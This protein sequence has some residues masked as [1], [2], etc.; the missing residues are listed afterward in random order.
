MPRS[1][2]LDALLGFGLKLV[3]SV[4][5]LGLSIY[6]SRRMGAENFGVFSLFMSV[7]LPLSVL[8]RLGF[9]IDLLRLVSRAKMQANGSDLRGL[10]RQS[11]YVV[12]FTS[13]G[14]AFLLHLLGVWAD[15]RGL[16]FEA[17]Q[18]SG[19][20]ALALPFHA[21]LMLN[22]AFLRGNHH[23][24]WAAVHENLMVNLL[25]FGILLVSIEF[26]SLE[27]SVSALVMGIVLASLSSLVHTAV[28]MGGYSLDPAFDG[29]PTIAH[30]F[31]NALPI[32]GTS[33]ASIGFATLDVFLLSFYVDYT[34]LG[35]YTAAAKLVSFVSFPVLAVIGMVGPRMSDADARNDLASIRK[36]YAESTRLACLA[37]LPVL[38]AIAV[39]PELLL[40]IFGVGFGKAVTTVYIL[41]GGQIANLLMGP[42]GYLLWMTGHAAIL[43]KVTLFALLGF[44]FSSLILMPM[45]GMDGAA[46]ALSAAFILKGLGCAWTVRNR[47]GIKPIFWS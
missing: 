14:F 7:L 42:A 27:F 17:L 4:T 28:L 46:I 25:V 16:E 12:L 22:A 36:T 8:V 30:R 24:V 44:I 2:I 9:D 38:L 5:L 21:M 20:L 43:Q 34:D 13:V 3:G 32:L 23:V 15:W 41:I 6:L 31:R 19:W 18:L 11:C 10:Y 40:S 33:L 1:L 26:L 47:L 35:Y 45:L 37:G 39:F 29:F